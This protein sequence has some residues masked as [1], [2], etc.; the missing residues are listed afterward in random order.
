M[1]TDRR[2]LTDRFLRSRPPA[3]RGQRV[4]VYDARLPGF[5]IRISDAEDPAR[6]GKAGRISF[7]LYARFAAGAAPT[8]RVLGV[9][10][11]ITLQDARRI[12]GEW[13]SMV[14]RGVDP[15]VIEDERR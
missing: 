4:E 15:G 5:G 7:I 14:A 1:M 2:L 9:Y 12:A 13:R 10:P 6:R 8:R 3:P 11:T